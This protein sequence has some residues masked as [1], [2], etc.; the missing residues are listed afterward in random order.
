MTVPWKEVQIASF[1]RERFEEPVV[2][3]GCQRKG[4]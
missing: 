2:I 4:E 1:R 3:P